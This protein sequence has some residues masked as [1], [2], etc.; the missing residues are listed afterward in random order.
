MYQ[1]LYENN[2]DYLNYIALDYF[3]KTITY[4]ELFK[5][6]DDAAKAFQAMGRLSEN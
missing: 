2:V 1:Y 4:R 3:G 5:H 6:I